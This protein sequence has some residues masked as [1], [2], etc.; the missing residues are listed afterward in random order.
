MR[1]RESTM[2]SRELGEGLRQAMED[3]DLNGKQAAQVF[4]WS[5]S[6]VSRILSGKRGGAALDVAAFLG[7]CGVKTPERDRLLALCQDQHIPGWPQQHGS[8]L[9]RQLMALI[10]Y[11]DKAVGY[12]DIQPMIVPGLL[13]A[14]DY[15]RAVI[16]YLANVPAAEVEERVTARLAR[17]FLFTFYLHESALRLPVGGPAVMS[18]QLHHLLRMSVRCAIMKQPEGVAMNKDDKPNKHDADRDGQGGYQPD[19]T[20]TPKHYGRGKHEKD[21]PEKDHKDN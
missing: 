19:K 15:A 18:D 4:G 13:Q 7:A 5:E 9:P 6:W 3:A 21:D 12:I 10:K 20:E 11:E 8:R 2:R 17:Q 14:G 1:D 16:S